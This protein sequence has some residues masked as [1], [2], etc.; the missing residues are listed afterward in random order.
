MPSVSRDFR[1][2]EHASMGA[3]NFDPIVFQILQI[4][5][6]SKKSKVTHMKTTIEIANSLLLRAKARAQ[7]RQIMLRTLIEES[8]A[9]NLDQQLPIAEIRPITFK[10]NGLSRDFQDA[11][12]ESIREATYR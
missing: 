5:P 1:E 7:E 11:S 2:N 10:G 9:A 3:G 6:S 12:W 8:L 4:D